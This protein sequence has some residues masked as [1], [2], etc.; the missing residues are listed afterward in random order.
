[1]KSYSFKLAFT[2]AEV[3]ITLGIIGVVAALTIP[4]LISNINN[5]QYKSAYKKAYSVAFQAWLKAYSD[6]GLTVCDQWQSSGTCA[7]NNF[8]AFQQEMAI[9]KDC[10]T[11]TQACWEESG[12]KPFGG[13]APTDGAL[14]FI[15]NSG[16][17]WSRT[18]P[19]GDAWAQSGDV[20]VDINANKGPNIYGKDRAIFIF[21]YYAQDSYPGDTPVTYKANTPIVGFLPDFP[22]SD[23]VTWDP[24]DQYFRCPS[25]DTSPCYYTSWI[26]GA[27]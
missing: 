27:H 21:Y 18:A 26:T 10:G 14:A 3:L 19:A 23:T 13:G 24:S 6:G 9:S 12:E 11:N 7:D 17:A 15:D 8:K 20:L 25:M 22:D 2:L 1:M 4:T 16:V 5:L